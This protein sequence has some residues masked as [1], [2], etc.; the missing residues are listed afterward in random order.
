MLIFFIIIWH[1]MVKQAVVRNNSGELQIEIFPRKRF[2]TRTSVLHIRVVSHGHNV[3]FTLELLDSQVEMLEKL[4]PR[5]LEIIYQI[6][7]IFLEKDVK[8]KW[9]DGSRSRRMSIIEEPNE[10]NPVKLINM[11]HLAIV[12]SH[13]VN[14]VAAIHSEILRKDV[15][16][17][18]YELWPQKFQNKTNGIT[19]RRWLINCNV[20]LTSFICEKIGHLDGWIRN[21]DR[22]RELKKYADDTAVLHGLNNVKLQNKKHFAKYLGEYYHIKINPEAMFDVQVKLFTSK[23][24]H[25]QICERW[26]RAVSFIRCED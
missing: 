2:P 19:P 10:H 21:L 18:F 1:D 5:H 8:K 26:D 9:P 14:G 13:A 12:G 4:L 25:I 20:L 16:R 15:F 17:D 23:P 11:A 7:W 24:G 6:N 22:L 3:Y